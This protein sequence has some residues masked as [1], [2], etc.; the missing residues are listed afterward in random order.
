VILVRRELSFG[1]GW[2]AFA[3]ALWLPA[4]AGMSVTAQKVAATVLLMAIW[5]I[6]E[7]LP[8]AATALLPLALFPLL[9]VA[10]MK[11]LAGSYAHH[12]VFLFLGGFFIAS[13]IQKWGLHRRIALFVLRVVGRKPS[14]IVLGFM[15]ATAFLSMWISNTATA[16][17]MY[18]IAMAVVTELARAMPR[19]GAQRESAQ[20]NFGLVVML[21]VAYSA[22]IGGAGTLIGTPPNV[23]LAG[24]YASLFPDAPPI[25]FLRWMLVAVPIVV[26]TIPVAWVYLI[27]FAGPVRLATL[28]RQL[29]REQTQR[30]GFDPPGKLTAPEACVLV[31]FTLTALLWIL[32]ADIELGWVRIPGWS[33]L[34][35]N[36]EH[37]TDSSVA[38]TMGLVLFAIP[39]SRT[40]R[41]FLLDWDCARNIPW[42]ILLLFGGGFAI[43]KGMADS[44]LSTWIGERLHLLTAMPV[45]LF[46]I[47]SCVVVVLLTEVTS[48]TAVAAM[49]L[50]VLAS[51][52][53][54][55][56]VAPLLVMMPATIA[57]SF[58]FV[59][60]VATPP[61]AIV[62]GSGWVTIPQM[63]KAG[64]ML[65]L[66]GIA[67]ITAVTFSLG[68]ALL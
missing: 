7:A 32:R 49:L 34:L 44:G 50:P 6:G 38:I 16:M 60:P 59:L 20:A 13:A 8:L 1:L 66:A 36:P 26:V 61:N 37:I 53:A 64:I 22:S 48:N 47:I 67:I 42:G 63:A 4:P 5:W 54:Q 28:T 40:R 52:A 24:Q 57:A 46:V 12:L 68:T 55:M 17:M 51:L 56:D 62:M 27:N 58:A 30:P 45:V 33:R 9:G 18:P 11:S 21:A 31:V 23:I 15:I 41:D 25:T 10:D 43:A 29:G 3:I 35:P 39:A 65:D 14:R 2:A 19:E